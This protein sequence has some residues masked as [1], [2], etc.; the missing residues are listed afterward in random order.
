[1]RLRLA[2]LCLGLAPAVCFTPGLILA[3]EA[4]TTV[5]KTPLA[6]GTVPPPNA[7]KPSQDVGAPE[8]AVDPGDGAAAPGDI[9]AKAADEGAG[10]DAAVEQS[11]GPTPLIGEQQDAAV[12]RINAY[13]NGITS[14]QGNFDQVD[15][16][17]KHTTGR[18]Y[19]Q[20]PGKLRFDYA[21]PSTI[22]IVSDGHY[23]AIE[24]S[25]LKTI[26][27]YPIKSTPFRLLLGEGVN[28]G[29]DA[30][31]IGVDADDTSLAITLV[32]KGGDA[33]GQIRLY[34]DTKPDLTLKQWVIVDAQGLATTVTVNALAPGRKFAADFFN[35][36][37]S[38][39]PFR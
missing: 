25:D 19:V 34:F 11:K 22:R 26:E 6:T 2:W 10:W 21:A 36:T 24:D 14:L 27:K 37:V 13:F 8:D 39:Q 30:R 33:N 38:F 29:R 12:E 31:V 32:D 20:R 1:M 28:L 18:F 15:S 3:Q 4:G 23:L 35:S 5:Q 16:N 9:D 7:L 17:N